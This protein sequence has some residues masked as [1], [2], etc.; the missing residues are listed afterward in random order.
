MSV[1]FLLYPIRGYD[2]HISLIIGLFGYLHVK[3][4]SYPLAQNLMTTQRRF[5]NYFLFLSK[6]DGFQ[7]VEV[8]IHS[9][10]PIHLKS[11]MQSTTIPLQCDSY[12][13][14]K[15]ILKVNNKN[16]RGRWEICSNSRLK[17]LE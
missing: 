17:K 3:Q 10:L 12:P 7:N 11:L 4:S 5:A 2:L 16:T 15:Y 8:F 14:N 1:L 6:D 13:A 9:S